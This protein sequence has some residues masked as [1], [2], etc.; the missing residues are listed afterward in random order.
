MFWAP[1]ENGVKQF[2]AGFGRSTATGPRVRLANF[3]F[4]I[5]G[6]KQPF[7][8]ISEWFWVYGYLEPQWPLVL[9]VNPP[10]QG[11]FESKQG[12]FGFKVNINL[13]NLST[14]LYVKYRIE[15]KLIQ[16]PLTASRKMAEEYHHF[17]QSTNPTALANLPRLQTKQLIV[18]N[19][20]VC[21]P[22]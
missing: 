7:L 22:A 5:F 3:C 13:V 6:M 17:E 18:K 19:L 14:V 12:S 20:C 11:L 9:K 10:K 2:A 8:K 4:H 1:P 15:L 21:T 16:D